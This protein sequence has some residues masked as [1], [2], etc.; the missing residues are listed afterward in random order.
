MGWLV[1]VCLWVGLVCSG[2]A[3]VVVMLLQYVEDVVFEAVFA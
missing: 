3:V 2:G 1:G